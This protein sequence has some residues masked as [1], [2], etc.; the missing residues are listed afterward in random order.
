MK[1]ASPSPYPFVAKMSKVIANAATA[2]DNTIANGPISLITSMTNLIRA[3]V[4]LKS[5]RHEINL[6]HEMILMKANM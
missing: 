4:P 5:L 2:I 3:L 6:N 1:E